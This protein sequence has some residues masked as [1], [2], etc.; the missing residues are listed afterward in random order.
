MDEKV[1][2]TSIS[3]FYKREPL[4]TNKQIEKMSASEIV[5]FIAHIAK[6]NQTHILWEDCCKWMDFKM[7]QIKKLVSYLEQTK[8]NIL[9]SKA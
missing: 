2:E 8:P 3:E 9:R 5:G 6:D 4:L 7:R 1:R